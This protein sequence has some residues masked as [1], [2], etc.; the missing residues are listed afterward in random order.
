MNHPPCRVVDGRNK[1]QRLPA[2]RRATIR[3]HRP[4]HRAARRRRS[5]RAEPRPGRTTAFADGSDD[6]DGGSGLR[7]TVIKF[8][9]LLPCCLTRP[10]V[11]PPRLFG[12]HCTFLRWRNTC[13]LPHIGPC[14]T[15]LTRTVLAQTYQTRAQ[16]SAISGLLGRFLLTRSCSLG[17]PRRFLPSTLQRWQV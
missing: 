5:R 11:F 6:G 3:R 13:F 9:T 16:T 7:V 4:A 8:T 1:Q 15:I 10:Q 12:G 2:S 14:H 17:S